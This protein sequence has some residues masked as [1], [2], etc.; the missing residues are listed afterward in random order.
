M[1]LL[2]TRYFSSQGFLRPHQTPPLRQQQVP[3]GRLNEG[4]FIIRELS[5]ATYEKKGEK[6]KKK[7][8]IVMC[9][10]FLG[11]PFLSFAE[12]KNGPNPSASAYEHA[13]ENAK[14]KRDGEVFNTKANKKIRAKKLT[15]KKKAQAKKKTEEA[16]DKG[17]GQVKVKF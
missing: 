9:S 4:F 12:E 2:G 10:F 15:K 3:A 5:A 13:N 11:M 14:F 16:E 7:M 1:D 8:M 6:M 17:E